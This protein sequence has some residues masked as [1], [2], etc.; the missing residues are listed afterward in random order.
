MLLGVA[1]RSA[2]V[3]S[4]VA[5][6]T[7]RE[8]VGSRRMSNR[9]KRQH[10]VPRFYLNRFCDDAGMI[11]TYSAGKEPI[12]RKPEDTAIETNFYSP[13]V[14]DEKRFDGAEETLA[15]IEAAAAPLWEELMSGKVM[16]GEAQENFAI[17]L[18]SQYLRSPVA[19]GAGA[20]VAG[21]MVNHC[22]QMHLASEPE[23][24]GTKSVAGKEIRETF[25]D[26]SNYKIEVL[27]EAGLMMLV[28]IESL[29]CVIMNMTWTVGRSVEQH[30]I[31]SDSPI[32]RISDLRTHDPTYGDG[33]F[34]NKT[35]RVNFPLT[36]DRML[37]LAWSDGERER[38]VEIPK[39]MARKM[40]SVRTASGTSGSS[41]T[42]VAP[43]RCRRCRTPAAAKRRPTPATAPRKRPATTGQPA[44]SAARLQSPCSRSRSD[45]AKT[46]KMSWTRSGSSCGNVARLAQA[47]RHDRNDGRNTAD[48]AVPGPHRHLSFLPHRTP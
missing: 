23:T 20:Q 24:D 25:K 12:A 30:L 9:T 40:N 4:M 8:A 15:K 14:K 26:P 1:V 22:L 48:I 43:G 31:T 13:I 44:R 39:A 45:R 37:E 33:A 17:F 6:K 34:S 36:P 47:A 35:V 10:V 27:R 11:W 42:A 46:R 3:A 38:V 28:G 21:H 19:I 2:K 32:T 18:A 5:S 41:P 7:M 16:Q 29:A